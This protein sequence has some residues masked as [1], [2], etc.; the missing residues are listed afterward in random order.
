MIIVTTVLRNRCGA[1]SIFF[2]APSLMRAFVH[3]RMARSLAMSCGLLRNFDDASI[4]IDL[5]PVSRL[6]QLQWIAVEIG[7]RRNAHHHCAE[8]DLGRRAVVE[9]GFWRRACKP[10]EV[11]ILRP[12]GRAFR[13]G[14]DE[15]LVL[16]GY[17]AEFMSCFDDRT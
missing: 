11:K 1:Y 12:T 3:R 13:A 4:G 16:G 9:N 7:E 10:R 8:R 5:H 14:K 2:C 6:D 17:A 15:N